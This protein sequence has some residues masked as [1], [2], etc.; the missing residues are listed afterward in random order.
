ME[1]GVS[2]KN[3]DIALDLALDKPSNAGCG[4]RML[5][6]SASMGGLVQ[7]F[8]L[9]LFHREDLDVGAV[10]YFEFIVSTSE[11]LDI[12]WHKHL[13]RSLD[14]L[15]TANIICNSHCAV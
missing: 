10:I 1:V 8:P 13:L 14:A 2:T 5:L 9:S 6:M 4:V 12:V 11:G 7:L 3:V 15:S